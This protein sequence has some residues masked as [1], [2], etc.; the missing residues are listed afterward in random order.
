ME[1]IAGIIAV[2]AA[3]IALVIYKKKKR[4]EFLMTKYQDSEIV[5]KIMGKVIWT[6]MS[7]EQLVDSWGRP[8]AKDQKVYKTKVVEVFK[9]NRTGKNRFRSR[10]TVENGFVAGWDQK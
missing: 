2:I 1:I 6:G 4:R 9:Y 3:I 5:D 7:E 8:E 10:V